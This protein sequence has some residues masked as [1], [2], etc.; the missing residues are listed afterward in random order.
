MQIRRYTF[1]CCSGF[2][3]VVDLFPTQA[4]SWC[5]GGVVKITEGPTEV[6]IPKLIPIAREEG[7]HTDQIG[8]CD[9][10]PYVGFEMFLDRP[11]AVLHIFDSNGQYQR[12]ESW[13]A[14]NGDDPRSALAD[15]IAALPNPKP[16]DVKVS[17][18]SEELFDL[19]FGLIPDGNDHVEYVPY[20]LG[21]DPPWDGL[22]DT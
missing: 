11:I 22:Y 8:N 18:F 5:R 9:N 20:G 10:G 1:D 3:E 14:N 16:G 15:A 7:Y 13:D 19:T 2:T 6:A 4:A 17:T 12:T 21:F